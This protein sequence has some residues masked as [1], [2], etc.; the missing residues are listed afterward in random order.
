MARKTIVTS[1]SPSGT[2]PTPTAHAQTP[3][4]GH[5]P[6]Y[7]TADGMDYSA[8]EA[9][10]NGFTTLVKWSILALFVLVIFLFVVIHP[11]IRS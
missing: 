6:S 5:A 1:N 10:F 11:L 2:M 9:T 4:H 3:D 7:G 8:H